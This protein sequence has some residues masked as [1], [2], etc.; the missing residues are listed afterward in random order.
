M[1]SS[2]FLYMEFPNVLQQKMDAV[3][4]QV[5]HDP[6][7]VGSKGEVRE[8]DVFSNWPLVPCFHSLSSSFHIVSQ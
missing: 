6:S 8:A 1:N 2:K 5:F 4:N 3:L 7:F